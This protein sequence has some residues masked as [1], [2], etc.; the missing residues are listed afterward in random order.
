MMAQIA[1][2][3][4]LSVVWIKCRG[5]ALLPNLRCSVPSS[6]LHGPPCL[7][8]TSTVEAGR[9][10]LTYSRPRET[11]NRRNGSNRQVFPTPP[12]RV[13]RNPQLPKVGGPV[14]LGHPNFTPCLSFFRFPLFVLLA[15]PAR[16]G[17]M[18]GSG[19]G[20]C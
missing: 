10:D 6:Y 8:R 14:P 2:K 13:R 19:C 15:Q 9:L 4:T 18:M 17:K 3:V 16:I 7:P 1:K 11:T 5:M 20:R 12:S